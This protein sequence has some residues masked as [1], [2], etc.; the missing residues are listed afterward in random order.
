M[1]PAAPAAAFT[2][3]PVIKAAI[4]EDRHD[5]QSSPG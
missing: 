1:R 4:L 2:P 5:F 3:K